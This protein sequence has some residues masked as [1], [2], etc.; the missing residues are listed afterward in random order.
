[1]ASFPDY[2]TDPRRS[3]DYAVDIRRH[4][5]V[6][7]AM[8]IQ[9]MNDSLRPNMCKKNRT[10]PVASFRDADINAAIPA[11]LQYACFHWVSH[12]SLAVD[13]LP[14]GPDII[15]SLQTFVN[16]H[17]LHWFECLSIL[18][19][20]NVAVDCLQRAMSLRSVNH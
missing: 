4:H 9:H 18:K 19:K 16:E 2:V 12:L 17:L 13:D 3:N 8:C 1:H 7:A 11:G 14:A 20:L 10:T 6:L 5:L 15:S